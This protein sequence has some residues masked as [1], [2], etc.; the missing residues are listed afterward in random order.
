V[1][2][3]IQNC[4]ADVGSG[5]FEQSAEEMLRDPSRFFTLQPLLDGAL[6]CIAER[7]AV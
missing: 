4:S 5:P 3:L 2:A 7:V 1:R 6:D